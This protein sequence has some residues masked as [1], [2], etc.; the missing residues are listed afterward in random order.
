MSGLDIFA[1]IVL[2]VLIIT[3]LVAVV[4]LAQLPGKIARQREH[5]QA[6]AITVAGWIGLLGFGVFWPIALVWAFTKPSPTSAQSTDKAE[7]QS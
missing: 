5:P 6:E 2:I 3:A 1:W 7:A 4:V